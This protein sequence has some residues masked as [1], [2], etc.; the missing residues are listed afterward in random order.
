MFG[1]PAMFELAAHQQRVAVG[2]GARDGL[3]A[4]V[5]RRARLVLDDER[6]ARDLGQALDE[7]PAQD[8]RAAAGGKADDDL[9]RAVGIG[10]GR[11]SVPRPPGGGRDGCRPALN[12][13]PCDPAMHFLP[14]RP[15][16][17]LRPWPGD[18]SCR[19]YRNPSQ[20]EQRRWIRTATPG[21]NVKCAS[22]T[23]SP[24]SRSTARR[25]ATRSAPASCSRW[26]R[27]STS[28]R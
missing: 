3:R 22:R 19:H 4:D 10:L 25:S 23:A 8:I 1:P 7:I 21:T 2:L 20:Q 5:A 17:F 27:P 6:R 18:M 26:S 13:A 16:W 12:Q 15:I 14:L 9:D 28:S 11:S 24:G